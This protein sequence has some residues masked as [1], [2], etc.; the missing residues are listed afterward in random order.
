MS[1]WKVHKRRWKG[2]CAQNCVH[3]FPFRL[4]ICNE[5]C[6]CLGLLRISRA[7]DDDENGPYCLVD[8]DTEKVD[9]RVEGF[10][11]CLGISVEIKVFI[12]NTHFYFFI[13]GPLFTILHANLTV[14]ARYAGALVNM[15]YSVSLE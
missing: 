2:E 5:V 1:N 8:I 13:E 4:R 10:A 6:S 14:A 15:E 9:V 12:N 7:S 11:Y 3:D